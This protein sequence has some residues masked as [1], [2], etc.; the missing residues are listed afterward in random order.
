MRRGELLALRWSEVD[1]YGATVKVS[2]ALEESDRGL[3][4]KPPKTKYGRRAIP[5]PQ[6]AVDVLR[7]HK[8]RQLECRIALGQ[9]KSEPDALVF[10]TLQGDPL[11]R[12]DL[13][14]D[15][16][17]LT[18]TLK[19]P[20]VSF[21]SLRHSH[22]SALIASGLDVL[23]ISRRLGHGSPVVTLGVYGHM[24]RDK[25]RRRRMPSTPC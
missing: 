24:F 5:L 2:H 8:V 23:T 21:H 17:R 1:L 10:S 20:R 18:V 12:D 14:R 25:D 3:R 13:S 4:F 11:S 16:W 22:A 9:G 15:W 19:L 7:A 6:T